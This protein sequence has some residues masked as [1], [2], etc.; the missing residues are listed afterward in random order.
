MTDH[1]EMR[2]LKHLTKG[3]KI[4]TMKNVLIT[5]GNR[6]KYRHITMK[7]C[8]IVVNCVSDSTY[9]TFI[10]ITFNM[11]KLL[12]INKLALNQTH[13]TNVIFL[14]LYEIKPVIIIMAKTWRLFKMLRKT[15]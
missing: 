10:Y 15:N 14:V 4:N 1:F 7:K 5:Y 8:S 3:T 11:S 12:K 13:V 6:A 9:I 2:R